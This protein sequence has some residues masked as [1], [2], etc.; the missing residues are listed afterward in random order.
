MTVAL[1]EKEVTGCGLKVIA[2]AP[3]GRE[4]GR[5]YLYVLRNDLHLEPFGFLEDVWVDEDHRGQGIFQEIMR[6]V[7]ARAREH[8]CYKIVATSRYDRPRVHTLYK[9]LGFADYGVEFRMNL[10]PI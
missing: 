5:A 1:K 9:R 10:Q 2:E 3:D 8:G 4:V 6:K 7:I